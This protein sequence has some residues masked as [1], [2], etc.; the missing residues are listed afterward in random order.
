MSLHEHLEQRSH[1]G[2]RRR[3][4]I[5]HCTAT[6]GV[7]AG[8]LI[9]NPLGVRALYAQQADV[10]RGTVSNDSGRVMPGV[11]VIATMAPDLTVR[12]AVTDSAGRYE[13]R[14]D[15]GTGDYLVY[16]AELGYRTF[17]RRVQRPPSGPIVVDIRLVRQATTLAGVRTTATRPRVIP[18]FGRIDDPA[19]SQAGPSRLTAAIPAADAGDLTAVAAT[20]P[21]VTVGPDG[22]LVA[23]GVPGQV[24][25]TYNGM[26]F[27]GGSI[28]GDARAAISFTSS[29]YDPS[30]GGFG[31]GQVNIEMAQGARVAEAFGRLILDS[32]ALQFGESR[33]GLQR[34]VTNVQFSGD[35]DGPV[36]DHNLWY[37]TG[38]E[39]RRRTTSATS[40]LD[41]SATA[42]ELAGASLDSLVRLEQTAS[43]LGIPLTTGGIPSTNETESISFI[44]RLDHYRDPQRYR[45]LWTNAV[46]LTA[47]GALSHASSPGIGL[48]T[49]PAFGSQSR[50]GTGQ[51][52]GQWLHQQEDF[53]SALTTSV[54]ATSRSNAPYLQLPAAQVLVGSDLGD[55]TPVVTAI[56]LGGSPRASSSNAQSNETVGSIKFY[57][58]SANQIKIYMRSLL[59]RAEASSATNA[60]GTFSYASLADF[61]ANRPSAFTRN[62]SSP[63]V[64][65][66]AWRGALAMGDIW[67]VTP[68]LQLEPGVRLEGEHV[69]SA[70][71]EN[72]RVAATF[73]VSN[74]FMPNRLHVSPRLGFAWRRL[75]SLLSGSSGSDGIGRITFPTGGMLSG[76]IGEFRNELSTASLLG[77]MSSTGLG[78]AAAQIACI[79][80]SVPPPDW[81]TYDDATNIPV[82]CAAG[83]SAA[84]IDTHPDVELFDRS[85]DLA[86]SW[87][88]DLQWGSALGWLR[89]SLDATYSHNIDQPGV[90]DL[91]FAGQPRFTL[92]NEGDRPVFVSTD[93]ID[94]AT[95]A[96]SPTESRRSSEFARVL[97]R[98]SDIQSTAR[99]L[100][101]RL[102]PA[103]PAFSN[104]VFSTWYTLGDVTQRVRGFD[105]TTFGSPSARQ[106]E[107]SPF[108]VRHT[109]NVQTGYRFPHGIG[110][111]LFWTIR[112]GYPYTPMVLEDING[113]G[114]ANDRAFVFDPAIVSDSTLARGMSALL[115]GAPSQA[116]SCLL[117]QLNEPAAPESCR[118][119]WTAT[120]NAAI[121]TS[122]F[123]F[124]D[125]REGTASISLTNVLG[126]LDQLIHGANHLRGWGSPAIPDQTL[127]TVR[128]FDP[129]TRAFEYDVNPR[130]GSTRSSQTTLRVPFRLTMNV[131][132][133]LGSP[134]RAREFQRFLEVDP[135]RKNTARA[136]IDSLANRLSEEVGSGYELLLYRRDSLLLTSEQIA[137]LQRADT[138]YIRKALRVWR[139]IAVY[140]DE[141]HGPG[142]VQEIVRRTDRARPVVWAIQRGELPT[143]MAILSPAQRVLATQMLQ[144]LIHSKEHPPPFAHIF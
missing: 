140:I 85:F 137:A 89:Y 87:R 76:G 21:G 126:G 135:I 71:S 141:H 94:G 20:L 9:A 107:R 117:D 50:S 104:F 134:I 122:Y 142:D 46:S 13:L 52:I 90:V 91:N 73:G 6:I 57:A 31:A 82:A 130:F 41:A 53:A 8:C 127:Y 125:G 144:E 29:A 51:V 12:R 101:L 88:G 99:Q 37:N 49:A 79:A 56:S 108:D 143:M 28:P 19:A 139:P 136:P 112:S 10:I 132:V 128:G 33:S 69:F 63:A 131:R 105:G 68:S 42:T 5:R 4:A 74:S 77:P 123:H 95:G 84:L 45:K 86:R 66:F 124:L 26:T 34:G 92:S 23:F 64:S 58:G 106:R 116:R 14:F 54:S 114:L 25:K 67:R 2:R 70:P 80:A 72:P 120:M 138:A 35:A 133:E 47:F 61:E 83:A 44:G 3:L 93:A 121:S 7:L 36:G 40:L 113:D 98:V 43:A 1:T 75:G 96:V 16:A 59:D 109:I 30:I 110:A 39:A 62:L 97:D 100:T 18:D 32:P 81:P 102:T 78:G 38:I 48:T 115:A 129:T 118:G 119:P 15:P 22:S 24:S 17:R 65:A 11:T 60:L 111:S 55:S 27:A 103:T